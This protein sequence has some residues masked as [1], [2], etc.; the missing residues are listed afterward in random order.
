M[1]KNIADNIDSNRNMALHSFVAEARHIDQLM[2]NVLFP[3]PFQLMALTQQYIPERML[4]PTHYSI[5][6]I[7]FI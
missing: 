3:D 2:Q 1:L 4:L 7:Y 6:F 5:F